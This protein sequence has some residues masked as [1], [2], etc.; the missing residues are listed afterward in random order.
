MNMTLEEMKQKQLVWQAR[1]Q[2]TVRP[3]KGSGFSGLDRLLDGG[4]PERGMI[5]LHTPLGIGELRLLLPTLQLRHHD[6]RLLIFIAPPHALCATFWQSA[7]IALDRVLIIQ[8]NSTAERL[9]AAEQCLRSG[10]CH[11]V[12]CWYQ[13]VT[14]AQSKRLQLAAEQG[15]ALYIQLQS[16]NAR[17]HSLPVPLALSLSPDEQ[18]L[19]IT[20]RKQRG[21]VANRHI[22]VNMAS[23]WPDLMRIRKNT[24]NVIAFPQSR[25][26]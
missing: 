21:G 5:D 14:V 20:L 23:R 17:T 6:E 13:G 9:W 16:P 3:A 26:G 8:P 1:Q 15:D 18:G 25:T 7:D 11:S 24:N 2:A 4:L 22:R 12:L 10:C 19:A